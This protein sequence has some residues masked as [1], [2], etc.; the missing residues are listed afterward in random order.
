M[1]LELGDM[2][3]SAVNATIEQLARGSSLFSQASFHEH[4]LRKKESSRSVLAMANDPGEATQKRKPRLTYENTYQLEPKE[5]FQPSKVKEIIEDVL[6]NTLKDDA[7]DPKSCRQS[8]KTLCEIIKGRV[9]ELK[10]DRYKIVVT[11]SIGQLKE[12]GF[13]MGS[14]CCWDAKQDTFATG[15]FRNKTLF[16]VGTVWG[17]Y[18]E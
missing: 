1:D 6:K 10:Y 12:Q 15:S 14:R 16:A 5:K 3:E 7:Y 18:Y 9:K 11:V 17:V 13:R 4:M 8:V 2:A